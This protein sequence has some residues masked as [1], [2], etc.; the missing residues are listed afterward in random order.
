MDDKRFVGQSDDFTFYRPGDDEP[1][2]DSDLEE[3]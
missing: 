3:E 2:D 1:F